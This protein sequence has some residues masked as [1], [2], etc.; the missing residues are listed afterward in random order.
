MGAAMALWGRV[1]IHFGGNVFMGSAGDSRG[2][3][4]ERDGSAAPR[5]FAA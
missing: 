1:A 4:W 5:D 3:D 2:A